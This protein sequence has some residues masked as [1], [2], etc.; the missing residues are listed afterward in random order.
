MVGSPPIN[1]LSA[2]GSGDNQVE[3]PFLGLPVAAPG[4]ASGQSVTLGLRP[5][6]ISLAGGGTSRATRFPAKIHLTEPLGDVT[7]IDVTARET[8]MKMVL[9]EEI[10][11]KY[12]VGDDIE[13]AFD[14]E[15]LH[16]FDPST[17]A[18]LGNGATQK[19]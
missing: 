17:G 19:N 4:V 13:I 12:N 8:G 5:H 7:V 1:F 3:L 6:D 2:T 16:V 18:R 15:D 9:R 14:P 10:A 11:A